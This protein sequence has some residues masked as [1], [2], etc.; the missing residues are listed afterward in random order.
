[1]P[2][3]SKDVY[4]KLTASNISGSE[5]NDEV[6]NKLI[7]FSTLALAQECYRRDVA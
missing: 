3:A 5:D 4:P 7:T 2:L 6:N 1:M